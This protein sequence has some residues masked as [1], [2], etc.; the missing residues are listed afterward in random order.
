MCKQTVAVWRIITLVL[1]SADTK[2]NRS[3]FTPKQ[4]HWH[5]SCDKF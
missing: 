1:Q 3:D 5:P 2:N 4:L